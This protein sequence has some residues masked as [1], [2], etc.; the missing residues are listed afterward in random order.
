M[1]HIDMSRSGDIVACVETFSSFLIGPFLLENVPVIF[2]GPHNC[3]TD[4]L[5]M[6]VRQTALNDFYVVQD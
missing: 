2:V 6:Q 1:V 5:L 3:W 4:I